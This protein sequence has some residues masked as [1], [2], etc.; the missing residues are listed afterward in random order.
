[1]RYV[2]IAARLLIGV[3]FVIALAGK[4]SGGA[5]YRDFV[6]S[7]RRMDVLSAAL[8]SAA[9]RGSLVA[10]VAIVVLLAVPLR[11][12]GVAGFALAAVMLTVFAGA[13]AVSLR[14]GNRAPCRCF[15]V[16]STPLGPGHIARNAVLVAVALAGVLA[17]ARPGQASATGGVVA[18]FAGLVGGLVVTMYDDIAALWSPP[19]AP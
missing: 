4:V 11:A 7:L 8:V 15:G 13:I 9:A 12:A 6:L 17:A 14:R 1:V 10:E 5:A 2:E 19:W 3:V 18:A 16:S